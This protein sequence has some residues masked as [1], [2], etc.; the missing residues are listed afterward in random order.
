MS[1]MYRFW[2][3]T[4][5][6]AYIIRHTFYCKWYVFIH[7]VEW[8][9][10]TFLKTNLTNNL[11]SHLKSVLSEVYIQL[12]QMCQYAYKSLLPLKGWR[13]PVC[14]P[15]LIQNIYWLI[16]QILISFTKIS[17]Q[18]LFSML[19]PVIIHRKRIIYFIHAVG[20]TNKI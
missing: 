20:L 11:L 6:D 16:V 1:W 10:N 5:F 7:F 4:S 19:S 18:A 15:L 13:S 17:V 2:W 14:I 9:R 8:W 3:C 12:C